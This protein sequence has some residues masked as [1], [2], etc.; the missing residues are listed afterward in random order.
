MI[1]RIA[2]G[3]IVAL[4]ASALGTVNVQAQQPHAKKL[5]EYG[6]DVPNPDTI[7]QNIR[8][9]EKLPFDGLIFR[10]PGGQNI[11][12]K[13]KWDEAKFQQAMDDCKGIEWQKF[14]DNF[15]IVLAAST[16]DW[17][18]DADWEA[19]R[20]N[21]GIVAKAAALARCRGICFDAEP[22]GNN[23]WNYPNQ[24]HA[25][26]KSFAEYEAKARQRGA[27]FIQAVTAHMPTPVIHTFFQLSLFRGILDEPDPE[28]R[29]QKLSQHSYALLPAFLNGMLDA[30]GPDVTI[31]DGNEPSYYYT[32]PLDYYRV[33]HLIRQSALSMIA[34]ENMRK[35]QTQVQVSQALYVDYVFA[36]GVWGERPV[37]A[38][39][40]TPEERAKWFEH[41]VY[42]AL[43]T[44][45]EFVWLYSEKMNWWKN[46]DLP[47][48][49][50]DAVVSARAKLAERKS[51]GFEMAD[52][53]KAAKEKQEAEMR[54][55]LIRRTAQVARPPD[56]QA[57][58]I[59]GK[60]DDA[61]WQAVKPLDEFVRYA[62]AKDP[63]PVAAT[64][65]WVT[66]DDRN[67]YIA[68]QCAEPAKNQM[69][70]VG[71]ARDDGVWQGDSLDIFLTKGDAPTPYL[72]FILNPNNVQWDA[73]YTTDNDMKFNPTWQSATVIG[74]QGWTAE[75]ALPWSEMGI[76][77][78]Q[79][80]TK[81]RANICRQRI[82]GG[83]QTCWSQTMG[84]FMEEENFG[85][86]EFK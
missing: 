74:D 80:G 53:L 70:I 17:F 69:K 32:N 9:M 71:Q 43:S 49:M 28:K 86:L 78:P 42:Y 58:A 34:P 64:K 11:L 82:P 3:V 1:R 72:H 61:A 6:W 25:K 45:D 29:A 60:L 44:T 18:S 84:G 54:A 12:T 50:R 38:R 23:P 39:M 35:Y 77:P 66:Y 52:I 33:Y 36:L 2:G 10:I 57:P 41:N 30:A 56:G 47:P 19:V 20:N 83:E 67:L 63:K 14:T 48:G 8:E 15:A 51:L 22:Y 85:S 62:A 68:V 59:D 76:A 7:R 65:A 27:E 37:P 31:T 5:I 73:L 75:V 26:E 21:V 79:P 46:V 81:L 40:L 13:E 24:A 16:M 4:C 55:K